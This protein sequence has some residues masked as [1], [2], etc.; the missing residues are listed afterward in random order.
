MPENKDDKDLLAALKGLEPLEAVP[1]DVSKRFNETLSRL[2]ME[3]EEALI[4]PR[5]IN[6]FSSFSIAAS[7]LVALGIGGVV[8]IN[9]QSEV[10]ISNNSVNES[11]ES[12]PDVRKDQNLFS[13]NQNVTPKE[14]PTP[15]SILNS[16]SNYN[17]LDLD[18]AKSL[19]IGSDWGV[20]TALP[21][22]LRVCLSN[23]QISS[24]LSALDQG[25]Y[26]GQK[27]RAAWS[28]MSRGSWNV[29]IIDQNCKVI[30]KIY[31]SK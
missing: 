27:V 2:I 22:E 18:L 10:T 12:N 1:Q 23:L 11:S 28:P 29:Y 25:L 20:S 24:Y 19:E 4:K 8:T 17:S 6:Q 13:K 30:D 14:V 31:L 16:L 3:K 26:N 7:F 9:S 15:I 21:R 5:K